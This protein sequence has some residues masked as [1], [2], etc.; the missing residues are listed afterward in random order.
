MS[1]D[2]E[3]CSLCPQ[4]CPTVDG[5]PNGICPKF[6]RRPDGSSLCS[7]SWSC[8]P[9]ASTNSRII[10]GAFF[11][12]AL[13]Y[14]RLIYCNYKKMSL[15][16]EKNSSTKGSTTSTGLFWKRIAPQNFAR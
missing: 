7:Q 2:T 16:G 4:G 13:I 1:V 15:E 14:V 12:V 3:A 10:G 5:T 9:N 6:W 8:M 11:L